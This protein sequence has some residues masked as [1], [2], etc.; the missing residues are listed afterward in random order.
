MNETIRP[1][2]A[3]GASASDGKPPGNLI[4]LLWI[5]VPVLALVAAAIWLV[6]GN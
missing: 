4:S 2:P 6:S 3:V 5:A 1:Q